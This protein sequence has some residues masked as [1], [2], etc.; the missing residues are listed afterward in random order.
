VSPG[1]AGGGRSPSRY[2]PD[3]TKRARSFFNH[4]VGTA[5]R[6]NRQ[7]VDALIERGEAGTSRLIP[8]SRNLTGTDPVH[9]RRPKRDARSGGRRSTWFTAAIVFASVIAF[10]CSLAGAYWWSNLPENRLPAQLQE[11]RWVT[12]IVYDVRGRPV[13]VEHKWPFGTMDNIGLLRI[14]WGYRHLLLGPE[15]ADQLSNN[16]HGPSLEAGYAAVFVWALTPDLLPHDSLPPAE[17]KP[18]G[19]F[20]LHVTPVLNAKYPVWDGRALMQR[21]A[22]LHLRTLNMTSPN[23]DDKQRLEPV[24]GL[25]RIGPGRVVTRPEPTLGHLYP[26]EEFFFDGATPG[27]SST[28]LVCGSDLRN[29]GKIDPN[30]GDVRWCKQYFVDDALNAIFAVRYQKKYLHLWK[31]NMSAARRLFHSFVLK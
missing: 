8:P 28:F 15:P 30:I 13:A 25:N 17:V 29:D 12:R 2:R 14:P 23:R 26:H 27:E 31:Q 11:K 22:E 1:P 24:F 21:F 18:W 7:S 3:G 16:V 5:P 6:L 9:S 19:R 10:A 20:S 4:A